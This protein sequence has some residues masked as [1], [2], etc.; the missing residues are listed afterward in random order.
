MTSEYSLPSMLDR[1]DCGRVRGLH[2]NDD[3][4][5]FRPPPVILRREDG[6]VFAHLDTV[7]CSACVP[8]PRPR[9]I[10]S[11]VSFNGLMRSTW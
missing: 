7:T 3:P 8:P 1:C 9:S 2:R 10:R 5:P 4:C 11:L 6:H